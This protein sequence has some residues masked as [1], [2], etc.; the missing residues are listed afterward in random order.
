MM[1]MTQVAVLL[2]SMAFFTGGAVGQEQP[3]A[4]ATEDGKRLVVPE[5]LSSKGAA[6][7][8]IDAGRDQIY[9]ESNAP[10]EK[11]K[12]NSKKVIGFAVVGSGG[13]DGFAGGEWHLPVTSLKTGIALRDEHI[14]ASDWLDA[15]KHPNVIVRVRKVEGAKLTKSGEGFET[16]SATLVGDLTMHGVTQPLR[17][18]AASMTVLEESDRTK[19]IAKGDLMAIR[20]S[21][22]VSLPDFEVSNV[23]IRNEKVSNTIE[24]D[25]SL[26][27]SNHVEEPSE[28]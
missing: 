27:L 20:A 15:K 18:E 24:I 26:Y 17:V 6:F 9:F 3:F 4:T 7:H 25:V 19:A 8:V 16:Y 10:L 2:S 14:A 21:M 22:E 5:E 11:I 1:K 23:A 12:G 28:G 13:I